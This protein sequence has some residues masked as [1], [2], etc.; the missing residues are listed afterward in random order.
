MGKPPEREAEQWVEV[1]IQAVPI[2]SR[3]RNSR[4]DVTV[5]LDRNTR[6]TVFAMLAPGSDFRRDYRDIRVERRTV[7]TY[8]VE[9]PWEEMPD[10]ELPGP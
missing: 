3:R 4:Y 7:R 6:T 1:R 5:P 2:R 10:G 9:S 8:H